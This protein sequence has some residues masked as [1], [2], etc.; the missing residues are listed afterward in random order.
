MSSAPSEYLDLH[1]NLEDMPEQV[2]QPS[3]ASSEV[4]PMRFAVD[5]IKR[6]QQLLSSGSK[7]DLYQ[8]Y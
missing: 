8:L 7:T 5:F 3:K 6:L 1:I 2:P 4:D